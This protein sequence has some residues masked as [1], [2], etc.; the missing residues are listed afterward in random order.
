MAKRH[1]VH[2]YGTLRKG[3]RN[4]HLLEGSDFLGDGHLIGF[5]LYSLGRFPVILPDSGRSSIIKTET[6]RVS[7]AT[8]A[9]LDHLEGYKGPGSPA[10][11]YDRVM[12]ITESGIEG[13]VYVLNPTKWPEYES[14]A[15]L[16]PHGDWKQRDGE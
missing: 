10:N 15:I 13:W 6:Y 11:F 9:V 16:L 2:V 5:F 12:A 8:L 3:E 4:H 14:K 1:L 7:G